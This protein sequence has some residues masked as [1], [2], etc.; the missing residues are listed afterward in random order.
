MDIVYHAN[1]F[2]GT[3]CLNLFSLYHILHKTQDNPH[4]KT[5][6]AS[7]LREKFENFELFVEHQ[8]EDFP[9]KILEAKNKATGKLEISAIKDLAENWKANYLDYFAPDEKKTY[10][11]LIPLYLNNYEQPF[12]D[13]FERKGNLKKELLLIVDCSCS[14]KNLM[15]LKDRYELIVI[16]DHHQSFL[17]QIPEI[18]MEK[19]LNLRV[20]FSKRNSASCLSLFCL[21]RIFKP[22]SEF[23]EPKSAVDLLR[24]VHFV[25]VKDTSVPKDPD[26]NAFIEYAF[27]L[28]LNTL[29]SREMRHLTKF[30]TTDTDVLVQL[31]LPKLKQKE[32]Y[33]EQESMHFQRVQVTVQGGVWNDKTVFIGLAKNTIKGVKHISEIGAE[34]AIKSALRGDSGFGVLIKRIPGG[35]YYLSLRSEDIKN[36][37]CVDLATFFGGGGHHHASGC[38]VKAALFKKHFQFLD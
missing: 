8:E 35:D 3:F 21:E 23:F 30:I 14:L 37:N 13:I 6:Y 28:E 31:G 26:I 33:I 36:F 7:F 9:K 19:I 16:V 10:D 2:D 22:V 18:K 5:T 20:V 17:E 12:L 15:L 4:M 32:I 29:V 1:C 25:D 34:L 24:K 27:L 38:V 11:R